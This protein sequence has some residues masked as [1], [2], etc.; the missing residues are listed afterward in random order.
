MK[1]VL[2]VLLFLTS[3]SSL[4]GNHSHTC[5]KVSS[6]SAT[7]RNVV[8]TLDEI[9]TWDMRADGRF[10]VSGKTESDRLRTLDFA[11]TAL[12]TAMIADRRLCVVTHSTGNE[13]N[14]SAALGSLRV[15]D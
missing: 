13:G 6:F 14:A 3:F 10:K 2:T 15:G 11:V 7:S 12:K 4:A 1:P 5:G 8:F 9:Y